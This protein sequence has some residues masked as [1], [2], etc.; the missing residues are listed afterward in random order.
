LSAWPAMAGDGAATDPDLPASFTARLRFSVGREHGCS[1]SFENRAQ[2]GTAELA[3]APGGKA[4]LTL[5]VREITI[6]G[7][8]LGSY[9][10]GQRDF[11]QSSEKHRKVWSGRA[12][13]TGNQLVIQ[14]KTFSTASVGLPPYGDAD[15]PFP[16]SGAATGA[17]TCVVQPVQAYP[18]VA[19]PLVGAWDT[20]GQTP[21]PIPALR[22]D[23]GEWPDLLTAATSGDGG[24]PLGLAE[25]LLLDG[26]D[27]FGSQTVV[28]RRVKP[29]EQ[30]AGQEAAGVQESGEEQPG[31]GE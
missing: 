7:P 14:L 24:L 11:H 1:Q 23:M 18:A 27:M 8:S 29:V 13:V 22:C 2:T 20:E 5:E 6:F 9:K 30:A 21:T 19:D 16:T 17:I 25:T 4:T 26:N 15:Y 12:S 28:V 10:Q 31:G 3:V